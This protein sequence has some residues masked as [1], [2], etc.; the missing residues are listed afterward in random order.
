MV[1]VVASLDE[2]PASGPV[3][4][5]NVESKATWYEIR[6]DLPRFE[7]FPKSSADS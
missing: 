2:D 6:D 7:G 1:L 4:H 3:I 5:V